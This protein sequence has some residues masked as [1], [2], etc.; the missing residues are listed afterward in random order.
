[1]RLLIADKL[2]PRAVEELRALPIQVDYEPEITKETLE[3]KLPGVGILVVR[4][5]EV[6]AQAIEKSKELNLIVRAGAEFSTIDV[7]AA[8]KH[9]VYVAHCPGRNAAA[10]AAL[11]L[12]MAIAS[13]RRIPDAVAS[14]RSGKWERT[15]FGK[16]EGIYGKTLGIAGL[17]A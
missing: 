8:A 5:T 16:A 9:G 14:L 12:G 13:D 17:G 10:G 1:M 2:H 7:R 11:V 15:E 6:T 3:A 4:S